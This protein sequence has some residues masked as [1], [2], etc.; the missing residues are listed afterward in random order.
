MDAVKW[1]FIH[2]PHLKWKRPPKFVLSCNWRVA[3]GE[4]SEEL[5]TQK[6]REKRVPE[7]VYPRRSH[8]P[9][10]PS[11][12]FDAQEGHIDENLIPTV[13]ITPI[14]EQKAEENDSS[15]PGGFTV[16][17]PSTSIL[18]Q[19]DASSHP[20]PSTI[21]K[22]ALEVG[23]STQGDV[24]LAAATVASALMKS[25]ES[26][27]SIDTDL[28]VKI[29]SDP[30]TVQ[31]LIS[32]KTEPVLETKILEKDMPLASSKTGKLDQICNELGALKE[33]VGEFGPKLYTVPL[34]VEGAFGKRVVPVPGAKP[35]SSQFTFLSQPDLGIQKSTMLPTTP[36]VGSVASLPNSKPDLDE[37]KWTTCGYGEVTKTDI[38]P[39]MGPLASLPNS[40]TDL[41]EFKWMNS[42]YGVA[43]K[44]DFE[45]N[46]RSSL[47]APEV[48]G[49]RP[50][51]NLVF[52]TKMNLY[53]LPYG[54]LAHSSLKAVVSDAV[55]S[56]DCQLMSMSSDALR[57]NLYSPS[58]QVQS[59]AC[60]ETIG[61]T[62]NVPSPF[63][64]KA[65]PGL[66]IMGHTNKAPSPFLLPK[67]APQVL[68]NTYLKSLVQ[69]H[70]KVPEAQGYSFSVPEQNPKPIPPYDPNAQSAK[71]QRPC[72]FYN[73]PEGCR[74]GDTCP[75]LHD[76]PRNL[77]LGSVM[78]AHSYK[79][80]KMGGE[81][82]GIPR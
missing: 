76:H 28:L 53:S 79:K 31:K 63:L 26:G 66:E 20:I 30:T 47:F 44:A 5:K 25:K 65:L 42:G 2:K 68:D 52:P 16:Q 39:I 35:I 14:E 74:D 18:S 57:A 37:F 19:N 54:T 77:Q 55:R 67:S 1:R 58:N 24:A 22:P 81:S 9:P 69:Q 56:T 50:T 34:K 33:P 62:H 7:A 40:K 45:P 71:I 3:A 51:E 78:G 4:E 27:S 75:Y 48:T 38:Q 15:S 32:R 73:R 49:L 10:S 36:I 82:Y 12:P 64:N 17:L 13:P 70:G 60:L 43:T 21:G 80:M 11:P 46:P 61:D 29:L 6:H 8:I 23:S 41:D 72:F 59:Q